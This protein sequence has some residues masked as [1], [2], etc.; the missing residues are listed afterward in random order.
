MADISPKLEN[1][2]ELLERDEELTALLGNIEEGNKRKIFDMLSERLKIV[3]ASGN[4]DVPEVDGINIDDKSQIVTPAGPTESTE[5]KPSVSSLSSLPTGH[6]QI[7]K[8]GTFSGDEPLGKGDIS[9]DQWR[10]EVTCLMKDNYKECT[11][12]LAIRR[13]LKSTAASVMLNL[14]V[15]ISAQEV[16]DKFHVVFGNVLPN[17]ILLED[18]YTARQSDSE[19]VVAWGCR[20]EKLLMRA[21]EQGTIQGTEDMARTKFWSGIR[22]ERVKSGLR[23]KFDGG[24]SFHELLRNARLLEHEFSA[25]KTKTVKVSFQLA[26]DWASIDSRL[27]KLEKAINSFVSKSSTESNS[28]EGSASSDLFCRYCKKRGHTIDQCRILQSK[29]AKKAQQGNAQQPTPGAEG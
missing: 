15:D 16:L 23:H 24:G 7:P 2:L 17:E 12:M 19:T 20:I 13:S 29:N 10:H 26:P 27:S 9:Y 22:D 25:M 6:V 18:F 14:G 4:V 11:V 28:K 21:K 3:V 5:N 8:I 1:E